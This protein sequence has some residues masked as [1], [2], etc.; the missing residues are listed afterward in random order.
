MNRRDAIKAAVAGVAACAMPAVA[1]ATAA[2]EPTSEWTFCALSYDV[3]PIDRTDL[4]QPQMW[5][6]TMRGGNDSSATIATHDRRFAQRKIAI[7]FVMRMSWYG[8][9]A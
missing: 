8:A 7:P 6:V 1:S 3:E 4:D 5:L 9:T 2:P